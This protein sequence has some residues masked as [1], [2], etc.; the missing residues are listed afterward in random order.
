MKIHLLSGGNGWH[1]QDL[2]RAAHYLGL[3]LETVLFQE[4]QAQLPDVGSH[5]DSRWLVR[6]MP[7]G[8]LEQV[9]FRMNALHHVAEQGG[10]VWNSPRSL[11]ICIDKYLCLEKLAQA[12]L[13][14]PPTVVCQDLDTAMTTFQQWQGD[15]VVKPIFGSEG[16]GL[17]R[18]Q[19]S[20]IAWRVF[21]AIL[22][23]EGV[24]YLQQ[25]LDAGGSD[26]RIFVL[27]NRVLGGMKRTH[28]SDWR[29]NVAQGGV[30]AKAEVTQEQAQLAVAAARTV[31]IS[32]GGIDLIQDRSGNSYL[33]EVNGVPGWKAFSQVHQCDVAAQVLQALAD[34]TPHNQQDIQADLLLACQW[35]VLCH[36]LGNVSIQRSFA[37]LHA[38]HFLA[39][40][41]ACC[42]VLANAP[43]LTLGQTILQAIQATQ[44]VAG[45]NTNLGIVLLL[46]PLAK[47]TIYD[48]WQW[49]LQQVLLRATVA[50]TQAVFEAIRLANP[51]GMG[52]SQEQDIREIPT[53]PL[54]E[55]MRFAEE[56]D[57]IARQYT[58]H[59]EE[60]F[61]WAVP[62][63]LRW[64]EKLGRLEPAIQQ[65]QLELLAKYPDSLISRKYGL[66]TATQ[67]SERGGQILQSGGINT[68]V[69]KTAWE[70]FD[71]DLRQPDRRLNPGTTAD[72]LVAC[73]FIALRTNKLSK[74]IELR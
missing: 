5:R 59:F 28:N 74:L 12:G 27:N 49:G 14:V 30:P 33:L 46:A 44:S 2:Q 6:T 54:V 31:G 50:D 26:L 19:D 47:A 7:I 73:L 17:I 68:I 61:S 41:A 1:V 23:V 58:T 24:I 36:K 9:I 20:E 15:V 21:Q 64:V 55:V 18:L 35:D 69:G 25:F 3:E 63:L 51:G 72:L 13:P 45:T 65:T 40:A 4:L 38:G 10:Y 70:Q 66:Q 67:V 56:K 43:R 71:S 22:R 32:Y 52:E 48:D 39:S 62:C 8:S 57:L 11:E 29:A 53:L 34:N 42:G 16:R 60:L 37:D